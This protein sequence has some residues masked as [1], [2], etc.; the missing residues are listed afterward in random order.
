[1]ISPDVI[2]P[3]IDYLDPKSEFD[4]KGEKRA[5]EDRSL[6]PD[7]PQSAIDAFERYKEILIDAA[8]RGVRVL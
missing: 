3:F 2:V 6:V 7:A 4:D 1:M 8:K 5:W